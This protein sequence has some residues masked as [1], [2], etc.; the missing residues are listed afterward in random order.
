MLEWNRIIKPGGVILL[1][2]P[3][4]NA[5]FDH[6]RPY[7]NINHLIND[8]EKNITEH[9][10]THLE[11]I[12]LLHDLSRDPQAKAFNIFKERCIHNYQNRCMHHHVFNQE[13]LK[14]LFQYC[15]MNIAFQY[16]SYTDHYIAAVK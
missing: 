8:Y 11:E 1:V 12:L 16:S 15:K 3:N 2:L 10:M 7:T 6:R 13:L 5:N 14:E 4:K 9:D